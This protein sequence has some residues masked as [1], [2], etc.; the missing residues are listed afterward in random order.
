MTTVTNTIN[1]QDETSVSSCNLK[2][3]GFFNLKSLP[4]D[5]KHSIHDIHVVNTLSDK[6]ITLFNLKEKLYV[7]QTNL[8]EWCEHY[9]WSKR[10][11][12]KEEYT[13]KI[14][15]YSDLISYV[16]QKIKKNKLRLREKLKRMNARDKT[17]N[18]MF[19]E[20]DTDCDYDEDSNLY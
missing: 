5:I 10:N 12:N 1:L 2:K 9:H 11:F 14:K 16:N 18:H 6:I 4:S 20:L 7:E 17:A 8:I 15:K 13:P 19:C 3:Q